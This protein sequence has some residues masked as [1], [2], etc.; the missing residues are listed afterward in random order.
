V[1]RGSAPQHSRFFPWNREF[2]RFA[3]S[4]RRLV[5]KMMKQIKPLPANFRSRANREF[6]PA[7]RE[8]NTS[9]REL[10]SGYQKSISKR[11]I[12]SPYQNAIKRKSK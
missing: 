1:T 8:L 4:N 9:N 2:R 11:P 3:P 7:N 5:E 12:T 6:A 10:N